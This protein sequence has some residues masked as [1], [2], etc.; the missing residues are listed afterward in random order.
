MDSGRCHQLAKSLLKSSHCHYKG[1][2]TWIVAV[3]ISW[4]GQHYRVSLATIKEPL[5]GQ[6]PWPLAIVRSA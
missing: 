6:W 4:P 2:F 1:E 3:A 5:H